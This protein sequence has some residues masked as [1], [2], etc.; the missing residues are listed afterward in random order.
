MIFFKFSSI[1]SSNF[2]KRVFTSHFSFWFFL[3]SLFRIKVC[4]N[5]IF[6]SFTEFCKSLFEEKKSNLNYFCMR[7]TFLGSNTALLFI[8]LFSRH[9]YDLCFDKYLLRVI[10]VI[11]FVL[12]L[13][14][15]IYY[16]MHTDIH[17]HAETIVQ[18]L[19]AINIVV[20]CFTDTR[21]YSLKLALI[22]AATAKAAQESVV[23]TVRM[24][25]CVSGFL[26]FFCE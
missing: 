9:V 11:V 13:F 21:E 16:Y 5:S 25:V 8:R 2:W 17:A 23:M 6:V 1:H 14:S 4:V 19:N 10:F 20:Y 15:F 26:L 12:V 3:L 18:N 7:F 24:F 22:K